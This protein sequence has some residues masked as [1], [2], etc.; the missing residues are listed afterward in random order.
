MTAAI[1]KL[2]SAENCT[3]QNV[4]GGGT[5]A[6]RRTF[7]AISL[8]KRPTAISGSILACLLR[9]TQRFTVPWFGLAESEREISSQKNKFIYER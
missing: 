9:K 7:A 4:P 5:A 8:P 1:C 2:A 6:S 3:L